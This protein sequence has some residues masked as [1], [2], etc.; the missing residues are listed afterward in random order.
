MVV[1]IPATNIHQYLPSF[2]KDLVILP[3]L[4]QDSCPKA[5]MTRQLPIKSGVRSVRSSTASAPLKCRCNE[6]GSEKALWRRRHT[7]LELFPGEFS[8]LYREL[9]NLIAQ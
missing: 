3:H 4:L 2:H 1:S 5:A 6:A 8:V 7:A 9:C